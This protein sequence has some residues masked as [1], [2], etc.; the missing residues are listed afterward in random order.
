MNKVK[1][2]TDSCSSLTQEEMKKLNVDYVQ[3]SFSVN[4]QEFKGFNHPI[5]DA[6][7]FYEGLQ[8]CESC[9]T[10]CINTQDFADVFEKYVEQGFDVF[11]IGLSSGLSCTYNNALIAAE[12]INQDKGKHVYI[13]DS[14]SGSFAIAKM[15]ECAVKMRD[16]GKSAQEIHNALHE[17]GLK[18]YTMFIPSD[19]KFLTKS[20]RISK[21]VANIGSMLNLIP[22]MTADSEGKLK[23]V[24]KCIG[25]KKAMKTIQTLILQ[26]AD[27][28]S[29]EKIYIGHTNFEEDAKEVAEFFKQNS[30]NKEVVVGNIDYTMGC[31]CG[32]KTLAVFAT[33]K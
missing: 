24:A 12:E 26:N 3:E 29:P 30:Q 19:L 11:Y 15:V 7:Q 6:N 27:L 17:N 18:T 10:S 1:I 23:V 8:K 2:I 20:G 31:C 33:Y 4:N 25:R 5:K 9:S 22:I 32:P 21:L 14:L 16:E 13:A 28:S